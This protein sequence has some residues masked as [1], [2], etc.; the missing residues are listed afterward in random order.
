MLPPTRF[1]WGSDAVPWNNVPPHIL[2]EIAR[3]VPNATE[4][5]F[6]DPDS[7]IAQTQSWTVLLRPKQPTL[8]SLVLVCREPVQAFSDLSQAAFTDLSQVVRG[9]E[10]MLRQVVDYERINYLMLM[11][12]DPDV[13]FHVIPR[14]SAARRFAEAEFPDTGWPGPPA[15]EPAVMPSAEARAALVARLRAAWVGSVA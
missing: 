6:G 9:A 4:L 1:G 8:G 3:I 2:A 11:M 14:Y 13:H 10:R 7:R 12:V 5:K 15:L